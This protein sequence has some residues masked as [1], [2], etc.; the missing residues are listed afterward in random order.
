MGAQPFHY[1]QLHCIY[2]DYEGPPVSYKYFYF[3]ALLVLLP[4]TE[5]SLFPQVCLAIF[6]LSILHM[7]IDFTNAWLTYPTF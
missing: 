5:P 1:C 3:F 6:L 2:S 7:Y 4:H